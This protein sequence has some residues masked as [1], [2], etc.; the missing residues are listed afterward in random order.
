MQIPVE[1]VATE[2]FY[3]VDKSK[4]TPLFAEQAYIADISG[5]T[6]LKSLS[7]LDEILQE[8][9][10]KNYFAINKYPV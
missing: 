8:T 6:E 7:G 3:F 2:V 4:V 9:D 10:Y 1:M 5:D